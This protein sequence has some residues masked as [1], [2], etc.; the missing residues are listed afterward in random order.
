MLKI[1]TITSLVF[2][3]HIGVTHAASVESEA[4]EWLYSYAPVEIKL[5]QSGRLRVLMPQRQITPQM[6]PIMLLASCQAISVADRSSS[7]KVTEIAIL[8]QWGAQGYV[9]ETP[10]KCEEA[11]QIPIGERVGKIS[12]LDLFI[13][14]DTHLE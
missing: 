2:S 14:G 6:Y 13:L 12:R 1:W 10:A 3:L 7:R 5:E 9:Y 4:G 8:N 11:L